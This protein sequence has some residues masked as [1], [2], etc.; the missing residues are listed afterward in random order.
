[1]PQI[2]LSLGSNIEP[3]RNLRLAVRALREQFGQLSLSP[4]Y[5]TPA[6]GFDGPSFLNLV[7]A[8]QSGQSAAAIGKRLKALEDELGRSRG[9]AKF[10]SRSIDI[11]LLTYGDLCAGQGG[12]NI[13]RDEILRYAFVL[14]PLA[15][16]VG[17]QRHPCLKKTYA[18]LWQAFGVTQEPSP[19]SF[20][21][22]GL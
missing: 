14:K 21:W 5:R 7:A 19:V 20:D 4:V 1:M 15:D 12:P 10:S 17:G 6:V 9:G 11:D 8:C 13:P 16:L 18:E 3:E 22:T 2:L